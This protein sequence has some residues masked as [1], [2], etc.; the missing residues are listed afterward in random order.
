[1]ASFLT[2]IARRGFSTTASLPKEK[3]YSS[4]FEDLLKT[5]LLKQEM[6]SKTKSSLLGRG[7]NILSIDQINSGNFSR[8]GS[9]E[10]GLSVGGIPLQALRRTGTKAGRSYEVS[11]MTDL[12]RALRSVNIANSSNRVRQISMSQTKYEKPGKVKQRLKMERNKRRF[13][14]GI[15][16]LFEIVADA[17]R[18]GY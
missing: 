10:F 9:N 13:D 8:H 14:M 16:R 4:V 18:K 2:R 15:R 5:P 17:R 1:M 11:G 7:S 6:A 3:N 12:G